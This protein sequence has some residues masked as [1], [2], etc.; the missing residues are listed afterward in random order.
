MLEDVGLIA[1]G[2]LPGSAFTLAGALSVASQRVLA[3]LDESV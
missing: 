2:A 3:W 1:G